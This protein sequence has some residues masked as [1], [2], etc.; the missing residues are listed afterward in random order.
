MNRNFLVPPTLSYEGLKQ[1]ST[2]SISYT[3]D[4]HYATI[5]T[6]TTTLPPY[7]LPSYWKQYALSLEDILKQ[8]DDISAKYYWLSAL[9]YGIDAS[10]SSIK[11]S[12]ACMHQVLVSS[13]PTAIKKIIKVEMIKLS[14]TNNLALNFTFH[15]PATPRFF[16][17]KED[18]IKISRL[19][20]TGLKPFEILP[21]KGLFSFK[22]FLYLPISLEE[23]SILLNRVVLKDTYDESGKEKSLISHPLLIKNEIDDKIYAL[24]EDIVL[25]SVNIH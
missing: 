17:P 9:L 21:A 1:T 5:L 2:R 10:A 22:N 24:V 19:I 4:E 25:V 11:A 16:L 7:V 6:V 18:M 3:N 14:Q 12:F 13:K 23:D 8:S 20:C 15:K